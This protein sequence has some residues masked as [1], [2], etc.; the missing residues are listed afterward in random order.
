MISQKEKREA[1]DEGEEEK[2]GSS[3]KAQLRA[4][5]SDND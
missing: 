1:E 2:T 5:V 3:L 4:M